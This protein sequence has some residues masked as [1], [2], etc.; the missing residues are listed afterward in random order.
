[1]PR[2]NGSLQ[3]RRPAAGSAHRP[4]GRSAG[5]FI[6]LIYG[7]Y[8]T[9]NCAS[10]RPSSSVT[11]SRPVSFPLGT[12]PSQEEEATH[13]H[14]RSNSP[15]LVKEQERTRA[16][17]ND[18]AGSLRLSKV[19]TREGGMGA[20]IPK[21]WN[22][23]YLTSGLEPYMALPARL[24]PADR[25]RA[26][27]ERDSLPLISGSPVFNT[28]ACHSVSTSRVAEQIKSHLRAWTGTIRRCVKLPDSKLN[29]FRR[30]YRAG[31]TAPEADGSDL[32]QP[33]EQLAKLVCLLWVVTHDIVQQRCVDLLLDTLYQ[34]EVLQVLHIYRRQQIKSSIVNLLALHYPHP[35]PSLTPTNSTNTDPL[36]RRY[37]VCVV[38]FHRR[39]EQALPGAIH[40]PQDGALLGMHHLPENMV[41]DEQFTP[42]VL[43]QLHLVVHLPLAPRDLP[44]ELGKLRQTYLDLRDNSRT[45][46]DGK[47]FT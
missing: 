8:N 29:Y 24:L 45:D 25:D 10:S 3:L 18:I 14:T 19:G 4:A 33:E 17:G 6:F 40:I 28:A 46:E 27:A 12:T 26:A 47:Q 34:V 5:L 35:S 39:P 7:V 16:H 15:G 32:W 38:F 31:S 9:E 2:L 30:K 21:D 22:H 13:T 37:A 20:V 36:S 1:M 42:A 23:R 43:Q 11:S 44:G 41:K